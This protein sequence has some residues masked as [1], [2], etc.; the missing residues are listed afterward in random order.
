MTDEQFT[1]FVVLLAVVTAVMTTAA[2]VTK[3]AAVTAVTVPSVLL[4]YGMAWDLRNYSSEK[5][6]R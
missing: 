3:T 2:V 6:Q 1:A 5:G 4:L